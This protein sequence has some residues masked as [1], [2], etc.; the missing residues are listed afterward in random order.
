MK[1]VHFAVIVDDGD[2][3]REQFGVASAA[4]QAH[5]IFVEIEVMSGQY[6]TTNAAVPGMNARRI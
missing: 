5:A 2:F 3:D 6:A 1:S 4:D